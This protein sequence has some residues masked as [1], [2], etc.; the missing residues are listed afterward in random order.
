MVN[1]G[2]LKSSFFDYL[3]IWKVEGDSGFLESLGHHYLVLGSCGNKR[4]FF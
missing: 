2:L 1:E 4:G 3:F